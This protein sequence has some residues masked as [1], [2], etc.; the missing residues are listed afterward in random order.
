VR[1]ALGERCIEVGDRGPFDGD[2][3]IAPGRDP[4]RRVADPRVADAK[5][6]DETDRAIDAYCLAMIAAQPPK[7]AVEVRAVVAPHLDARG[8]KLIPKAARHLAKAAHPI[9]QHANGHPAARLRRQ[10]CGKFS[11]DG[12]AAKDVVFEVDKM[13][14][15]RNGVE[16]RRVVFG[17]IP[18]KPHDV[19]LHRRCAGD[20]GEQLLSCQALDWT[21]CGRRARLRTCDVSMQQPAAPQHADGPA[22][23]AMCTQALRH[24]YVGPIGPRHSGTMASALRA[25]PVRMGQS[26]HT[27][28]A[29]ERR[30]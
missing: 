24:C 29:A 27:G 21:L 13:P 19:A 6:R 4:P 5:A 16:P 26:T 28:M 8:A 22:N 10:G 1:P 25:S 12:V 18:Q 30:R 3:G 20:P 11:A 23:P 2:A 17:A 9:I 14:R 7:R 15:G